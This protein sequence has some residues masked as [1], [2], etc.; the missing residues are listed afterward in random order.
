MLLA[1]SGLCLSLCLVCVKM[2]VI[3]RLVI[4]LTLHFN[5]I[6]KENLHYCKERSF[7]DKLRKFDAKW[8]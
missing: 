6:I 4:D 1:K 5:H 8:S 2:A 7:G 3:D